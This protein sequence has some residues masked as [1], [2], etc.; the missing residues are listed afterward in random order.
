MRLPLFKAIIALV[1]TMFEFTCQRSILEWRLLPLPKIGFGQL[2]E[3]SIRME[4]GEFKENTT[5]DN[6]VHLVGNE[7]RDLEF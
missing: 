5:L 2:S 7:W 6:I 4:K 3:S 1:I